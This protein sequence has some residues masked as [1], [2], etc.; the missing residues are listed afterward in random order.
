MSGATTEDPL[1]GDEIP[2]EQLEALLPLQLIDDVLMFFSLSS[3][4]EIFEHA[5]ERIHEFPT[6]AGAIV[7]TLRLLASQ[8]D[9]VGR[10]GSQRLVQLLAP[11]AAQAVELAALKVSA[12]FLL[13]F[14]L[15]FFLSLFLS[16]SLSLFLSFFLS[17]FLSLSLSF[18]LSFFLLSLSLFLSFFLSFSLSFFLSCILSVFPVLFTILIGS[19]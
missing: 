5:A 17:F 8:R 1:T 11:N 10:A 19:M 12:V 16:F 2:K 13:S 9:D 15:S 7:E 6:S 4:A 3:E 14:F 18:F